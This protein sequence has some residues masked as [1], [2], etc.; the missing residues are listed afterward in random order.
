LNDPTASPDLPQDPQSHAVA[1]LGASPKPERY[2][3]QA[4]R[5]LKEK[6]Y[7]VLPIHPKLQE[8]EALPVFPSLA[9]IEGPV[10][11]LTLYVGPERSLPLIPEILALGPGRVIFNPGTECPELETA[12]AARQIPCVHGCTLVMLKTRQF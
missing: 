12:L 2:A 4:I 7:R 9:A 3:N 11:T 6:G 10:H 1:V 5:L 8:V